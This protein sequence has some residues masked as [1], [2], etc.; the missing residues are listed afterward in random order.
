MI[1]VEACYCVYF[2]FFQAEDGIRDYK[3]TGV[4]T[5]ALPISVTLKSDQKKR[6]NKGR[7]CF[8]LNMVESTNHNNYYYVKKSKDSDFISP[9]DNQIVEFNQEIMNNFSPMMNISAENI[10]QEIG[11][12]QPNYYIV[13][14][15]TVIITGVMF[16]M[17]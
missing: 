17:N 4:Q 16:R 2:F 13:S 12:L 6:L 14:I 8:L 3:V 10:I 7:L 5:C 1:I 9:Y 15:I 11:E